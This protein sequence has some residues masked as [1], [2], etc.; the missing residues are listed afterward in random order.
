MA[1]PQSFSSK[2]SEDL[3]FPSQGWVRLKQ[4]M[5]LGGLNTLTLE[6]GP[7]KQLKHTVAF[8]IAAKLLIGL[9]KGLFL[10]WIGQGF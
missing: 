2:Y 9:A 5:R 10:S 3:V 1:A 7:R 4:G 8:E 6:N